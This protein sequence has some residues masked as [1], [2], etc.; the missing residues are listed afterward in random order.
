MQPSRPSL[1][2]GKP[3]CAAA[4][5]WSKSPI[6]EEFVEKLAIK[7]KSL[8]IGDP[9]DLHTQIG[10]V[11]SAKQRERVLTYARYGREAGARAVAGGNAAE[12]AGFENGYFVQPTVFADVDSGIR[13]FQEE[14]FGPFTSVTPFKTRLMR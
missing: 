2:Q 13:I 10:P 9:F 1:E 4:G 11:I 5:T 8:R 12:V 3:A 6:Y 7:A 14:V